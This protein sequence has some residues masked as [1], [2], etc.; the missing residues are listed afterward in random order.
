M[1]YSQVFSHYSCLC[2]LWALGQ[3]SSCVYGRIC[4]FV[5][6]QDFA[7]LCGMAM[8]LKELKLNLLLEESAAIK[9]TYNYFTF[10][11]GMIMTIFD[12]LLLVILARKAACSVLP[13]TSST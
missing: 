13:E 2:T 3:G 1:V 11:A 12:Q 9:I 7:Y 5:N 6:W 8:L 10:L 4:F